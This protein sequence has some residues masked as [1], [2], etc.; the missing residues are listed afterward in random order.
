MLRLL[1]FLPSFLEDLKCTNF[2]IKPNGIGS[3]KWR[4]QTIRN[5]VVFVIEQGVGSIVNQPRI[6]NGTICCDTD[7]DIGFCSFRGL[8]ITVK[9]VKEAA[10]R[11]GNTAEVAVFSYGII[12]GISRRGENRFGNGSRPRGPDEDALQHRLSP[13]VC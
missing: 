3:M 10:A 11:E 4:W 5:E 13:D 9:H 12:R 2:H 1:G 8:I 7:N 6:N